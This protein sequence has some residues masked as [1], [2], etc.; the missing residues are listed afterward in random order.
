[1]IESKNRSFHFPLSFYYFLLTSPFPRFPLYSF[2]AFPL[3]E[4]LFLAT[5]FLGKMCGVEGSV[6]EDQLK[7]VFNEGEKGEKEREKKK[8]GGEEEFDSK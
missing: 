1:M 5:T 8:K 7:E 6:P 4:A 3:S 2:P